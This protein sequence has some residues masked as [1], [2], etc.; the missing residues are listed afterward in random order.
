MLTNDTWFMYGD[1]FLNAGGKTPAQL[2]QEKAEAE[3][4]KIKQEEADKADPAAAYLRKITKEC[5][6]EPKSPYCR[7][8]GRATILCTNRIKGC[9]NT[10]MKQMKK[11]SENTIDKESDKLQQELMK[12]I[13][14][15]EEDAPKLTSSVGGGEGD[16]TMLYVVGG[17]GAVALLGIVGYFVWKKGQPATV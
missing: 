3:A 4:A 11:A 10:R 16:N 5:N 15:G 6:D 12:K 13:S 8:I 1:G 9:I 14:A 2:E 17:I 7:G